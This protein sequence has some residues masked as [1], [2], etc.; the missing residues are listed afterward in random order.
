MAGRNQFFA[1]FN[2]IIYFTIEYHANRAVFIEDRLLTGFDINDGQPAHAKRHAIP[3]PIPSLI[4]A[5]VG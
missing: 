5:T 4:W 1:E 2:K 3:N